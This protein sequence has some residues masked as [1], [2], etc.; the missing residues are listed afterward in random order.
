MQNRR[1]FLKTATL[2]AIGSGL[3]IH[4]VFA[5]KSG[6][7]LFSV[8][9]LGKGGRM[10]M[11]FFPYELKLKHVFTVAS[12]SR[13][14][15]PDVQVEIEYEGVTGYGEASMPPYLGQ[16]VDAVMAFLRKVDLE[17]F[18]DP[19]GL[20][21][22]LAYVDSLS[23]G[24]TAA[25]AAVDIALHDLVGKLLGAPWYKIWG[26]NKEKTPSTT[27]TIG[28]DT[29]D[30]VRGKTREVA[31]QFNI[32]KVKLGRDNDKEMI[33]T[34]RS[35]SALPIAV[36]ANQGWSDRQYA[37]D[38]I[39]WLKEQGIVMIEQPMPKEQLDDIAWITQQSPL[40]VFA[41][42][43]LQRLNDVTALKGAFTGINIKLMKC[44]GMREAWKMVTLARAL[45]MKV[46]VGCMTETSCAVSA[47]AQLSPVVDF[48]DLDGNL[49]ISNDRFKGME[50]INGKIT[51]NDLPGIGVD[52]IM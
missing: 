40:P 43:S 12:Y 20:E 6:P 49:L 37:L 51:L 31:G 22:I 11:R 24:D 28:I 50:V 41:D 13:T 52:L 44:T 39:H 23:P 14:T 16:T 46:M 15:T 32:L 25:K 47:A 48:A 17:Q 5:G 18:S 3:G 8:N 21:D 29:P 27:F 38:M 35:V 1:D 30:V 42:E 7:A 34:I 4:N 10:K 26:L 36:D 2:A 9:K 33:R 45:D 19:F